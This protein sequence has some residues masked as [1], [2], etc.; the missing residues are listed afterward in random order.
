MFSSSLCSCLHSYLDIG[1]RYSLIYLDIRISPRSVCL[2]CGSAR[3]LLSAA[4]LQWAACS[5]C[6]RTA[7]RRGVLHFILS[8][9]PPSQLHLHHISQQHHHNP[10]H[11]LLLLELSILDTNANIHN[12]RKRYL[13][14]PS[15]CRKR[16][17]TLSH[18][19]FQESII[20]SYMSVS[21]IFGTL[22]C[23]DLR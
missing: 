14:L 13:L 1:S 9:P 18:S 7:A 6:S 22:V 19:H 16:I 11:K 12:I 2:Q 20:I 15:P 8:S 23:K 17:L 5:G 10:P 4:V 21:E 3:P